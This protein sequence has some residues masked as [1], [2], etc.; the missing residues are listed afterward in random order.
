MPLVEVLAGSPGLLVGAVFLLGLLVGSFLNVVVHR[1]P[2]M[3]DREWRAQCEELAGREPAKA[4][5]YNLV[6]P[7]SACPSCKAPITA[8]QNVPVDQLAA[9]ARALRELR[10]RDQRALSAGRAADR[11]DVGGGGL[12]VRL[13]L[14]DWAPRWC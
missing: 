12:E 7:R 1:V 14:A 5:P 11:P 2:I 8:A 10:R 6:A 13:G 9:A 3:L 4:E